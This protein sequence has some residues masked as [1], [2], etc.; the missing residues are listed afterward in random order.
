[1]A[2]GYAEKAREGRPY[3]LKKRRKKLLSVGLRAR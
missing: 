2:P 3:F 1:M